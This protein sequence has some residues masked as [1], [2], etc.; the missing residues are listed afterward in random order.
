MTVDWDAYVDAIVQVVAREVGPVGLIARV[1]IS[2]ALDAW[3]PDDWPDDDDD[4]DDDGDGGNDDAPEPDPPP[5][6]D[7]GPKADLYELFELK[8]MA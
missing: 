4:D 5:P 2:R 7:D 6:S 1:E 3:W 8:V